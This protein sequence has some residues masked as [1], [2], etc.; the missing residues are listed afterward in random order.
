MSVSV[1]V[2]AISCKHQIPGITDTPEPDGGSDTPAANSTC[3]ADTA[4]FQQ[5]VLPIFISNCAISGCHDNASHEKGIVL[6]SYSGIL[7][8]GIHAGNPGNSKIYK[9]ITASKADDRMPRPPRNPL[10]Q[11]QIDLINKWI[12]QGAKNNSCVNASCDTTNIAYSTSI[13]SIISDNCQGCHS[14][15]SA[16]SG[17]DFSTYAGIQA[18]INDGKLWG[19]VN[20]VSGYSPMPKNGTKLSTCEL[21]KIKKWIDAGA[22]N[23]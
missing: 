16:A 19:A 1:I 12:V 20:H 2:L 9:I 18:K 10:S 8:G 13:T 11:Q 3:N 7:S 22:P 4:Y 5:Q 17:Y 6:T 23:N 21:A 15:S 14:G